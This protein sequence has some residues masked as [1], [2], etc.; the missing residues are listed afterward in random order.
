VKSYKTMVKV[1]IYA[2]LY[3]ILD[4]ARSIEHTDNLP[5]LYILQL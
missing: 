5:G 3:D 4:P 2:L 1:Y